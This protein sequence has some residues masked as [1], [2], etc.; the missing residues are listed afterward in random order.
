MIDINE[1]WMTL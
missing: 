1:I